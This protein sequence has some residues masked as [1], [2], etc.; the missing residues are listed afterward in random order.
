MDGKREGEREGGREGERGRSER[1]IQGVEHRETLRET[2]VRNVTLSHLLN[3]SKLLS[4]NK[5][6]KLI[7][8]RQAW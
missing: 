3:G 5:Q 2:K 7:W 6:K 1:L 8:F 4:P